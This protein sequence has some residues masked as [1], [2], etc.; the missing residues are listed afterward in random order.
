M[1][2]PIRSVEEFYV[3]AL[4]IERE[5]AER[6]A[7]FAAWFE[8][9]NPEVAAL[10]RRLSALER[11]HFEEL[12]QACARLELPDIAAADYRWIDGTTSPEASGRELFY[13]L[14][15]PRQLL[16]IALQAEW[17]AREF[18]VEVARTSPAA[19]VRELA[20]IMAAEEAEHVR[21]VRDALERTATGA[22][23]DDLI[24]H[25]TGPGTVVPD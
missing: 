7:E 22:D 23:W 20:S 8:R 15:T 21:W 6:Y 4:L 9:R 2:I 10:C 18:F 17:R 24:A 12:A 16:E 11:E 5:A 19:G 14:A 13:R 1:P 25:G 3:H